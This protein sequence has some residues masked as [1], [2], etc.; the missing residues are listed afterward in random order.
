[1][2]RR[3]AWSVPT[4]PRAL[5]VADV[6]RASRGTGSALYT[7]PSVPP[8]AVRRVRLFSW[9]RRLRYEREVARDDEAKRVV[10]HL[11]RDSQF[12]GQP[13]LLVLLGD[14]YGARP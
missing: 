11:G 3:N 12:A 4:S 6:V 14:Y 8:R 5:S 13:P 2:W 7:A 1:M 10:Y 9:R